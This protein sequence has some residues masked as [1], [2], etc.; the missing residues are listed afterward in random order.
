MTQVEKRLTA[1]EKAF[2]DLAYAQFK[3]EQSIHKLSEELKIFKDEMKD[4]KDEMKDFKDEMKDFKDEMKDFKDEMHKITKD[5]NKK[6]GDLAN[7]MGTIVEDLIFPN[8]PNAIMKC[9][10]LGSPDAAILRYKRKI[11]SK[12]LEKEFD[13]LIVY[14]DLKLVFFNET[15]SKADKKSIEEFVK[16]INSG[17]F[18]EL[19]PQFEG[20]KI[21]PIYSSIYIDTE[22]VDLLTKNRIFAVRIDGDILYFENFEKL[23]DLVSI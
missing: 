17:V 10:K 1:I 13:T 20:Y 7:K 14:D 11:K 12:K 19:L 22:L 21:I 4:F 5:L 6:W 15:K 3:T 2:M 18:Y 23:K 9:F 16:F 8:L